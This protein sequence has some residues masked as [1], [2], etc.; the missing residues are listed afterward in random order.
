MADNSVWTTAPKAPDMI[1][2]GRAMA[3]VVGNAAALQ[4]AIAERALQTQ[5]LPGDPMAAAQA[6]TRLGLALWS[7]PLKLMQTSAEAWRAYAEVAENAARRAMGEDL[8]PA[9]QPAKG[10]RRFKDAAWDEPGFDFAKQTYLVMAE[11][12]Q[13]LVDECEGLDE[14]TRVRAGFLVRQFITAMSPSNLAATNPAVVRKTLE[15]GG[16]NLLQ[17]AAYALEDAADGH[18]LVRRRPASTFELGRTIAATPGAVVFRNELLELI[19]YSPTTE[20]VVRRPVLM[21]PPMVNKFY[22]FDLQPKTSFL[23]WLVDQG[24][25]VFVVSWAN[26]D[27][28]HREA[29]LTAFVK[30]GLVEALRAVE[31][32]TGE[33]QVDLASFCLGGTLAAITL[34]YLQ[35]IGE[36]DRVATAT[37]IA[38]LTDFTDL[39]EWAAFLGEGEIEAFGRY[40]AGKGYVEAQD[41]A[42]LF[43]VV[44]SNDLIWGPFVTHYLMGEEAPASDLLFWFDDA[45]RMPEGLLNSYLRQVV[46]ENGLSR[47][48]GVI[49]DGKAIDLKQV[50]TP[51]HLIAMKDDHVSGWKAT[52]AGG[53]VF[54]GPVTFTLGGSGHNAGVINPPA[55]GK[56]GYWTNAAMPETAD[57]WLTGANRHDGSWWTFW[58]DGIAE[59]QDQVPARQPGDGALAA[60]EPAPGAY[61]RVRH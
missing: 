1:A 60:I 27:E 35:A 17:G 39:G 61:V 24:H 29:D 11:R 22:L 7:N 14:E 2:A 6:M 36:A 26:P 46:R 19:Q 16:V 9:A 56:H 37:L 50:R 20:T 48:G 21:A 28:A 52:F 3:D 34:G 43:S 41:L 13:A 10:D 4:R 8:A 23:K 40:L 18:G 30:D 58:R 42:R 38:A 53:S 49:I 45:A 59:G 55:A 25:T 47:A 57:A 31:Q 33:R 12:L 51:V 54:G 15:T 5:S 32:A 44:R